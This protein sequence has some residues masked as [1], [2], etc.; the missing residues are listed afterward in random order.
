MKIAVWLWRWP[1]SR[2]VQV[3]YENS[4][5]SQNKGGA[6]CAHELNHHGEYSLH[7]CF[8]RYVSVAHCGHG[9]ES[10]IYRCCVLCLKIGIAVCWGILPI[11][12][13]AQWNLQTK[14]YLW[15][16]IRCL[17]SSN[18]F[19]SRPKG[20]GQM[21]SDSD[22]VTVMLHNIRWAWEYVQMWVT[23]IHVTPPVYVLAP[24][25]SACHL[26]RYGNMCKYPAFC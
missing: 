13:L 24:T 2:A 15:A 23:S 10:P 7:V 25:F 16:E 5:I 17:Q 20:W 26:L 9:S 1:R 11:R 21:H 3:G 12:T 19:S 4:H 14:C 8:G 22:N 6:D 18:H